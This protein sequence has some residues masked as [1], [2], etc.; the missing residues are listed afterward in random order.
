MPIERSV[1]TKTIFALSEWQT[2][3]TNA[4]FQ[5]FPYTIIKVDVTDCHNWKKFAKRHPLSNKTT[6]GKTFALS[7]VPRFLFEQ[8]TALQSIDIFFKADQKEPL[9]LTFSHKRTRL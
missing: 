5:P 7:A 6:G 9:K 1:S 2:I 3:I 8:K 4:R